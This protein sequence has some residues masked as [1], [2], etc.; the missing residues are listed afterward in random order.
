MIEGR[1]LRGCLYILASLLTGSS[2]TCALFAGQAPPPEPAVQEREPD[3]LARKLIR[4]TVE[5]P[6]TDPMDEM[7]R[8]M[9]EIAHKLQVKFDPGEQTQAQQRDVAGMLDEAIKAAASRRRAQAQTDQKQMTDKRTMPA[10]KKSQSRQTEKKQPGDGPA[11]PASAEKTAADA[12][13]AKDSDN[14]LLPNTR[15]GWGNL[16]QRDRDEF[17]QG[18]DEEYLERFRPW[19]EQY[20]RALQES[21]R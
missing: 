6:V 15:R 14:P 18:A 10:A 9:S 16:P 5:E 1:Q 4:D 17:L 21:N 12:A 20:Y 8:V 11:K 2:L 13:A 3:D 19:I 7:M